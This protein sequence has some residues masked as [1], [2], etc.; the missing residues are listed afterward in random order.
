MSQRFRL[1][2]RARYV[3]SRRFDV[4]SATCCVRCNIRSEQEESEMEAAQRMWGVG[5]VGLLAVAF[6]LSACGSGGTKQATATEKPAAPSGKHLTIDMGGYQQDAAFWQS[7]RRGAEAAGKPDGVTGNYSAPQSASDQGMVQLLNSAI[8]AKPDGLAINYTGK[9]MESVT[10]RAIDAG[11][12]VELYNNN[13]FEG[14]SGGATT[15]PA[16]TT[17]PFVGQTAT[18]S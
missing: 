10:K 11:I 17:L 15:D 1:T 14:E 5:V 12:A 3:Y 4:S 9:V 7:I 2:R 13:R 8:A 6:G 16:I 18:Q